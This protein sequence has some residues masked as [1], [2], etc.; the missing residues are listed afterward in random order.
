MKPIVDVAQAE[1]QAVRSLVLS[2]I[3]DIHGR[4][5]FHS[6]HE[7]C[8]VTGELVCLFDRYETQPPETLPAL[9]KQLKLFRDL[10]ADTEPEV[11]AE[12]E[13]SEQELPLFNRV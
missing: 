3:R 1:W 4:Y 8:P 5:Q 13:A 11:V 7:H 2:H 9:L 12:A 10:I 6:I